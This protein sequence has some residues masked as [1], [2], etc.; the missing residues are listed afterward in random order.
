MARRIE[1]GHSRRRARAL[2]NG[3][4]VRP[5]AII[6][7][8]RSSLSRLTDGPFEDESHSNAT[9]RTSLVL[10]KHI[11]QRRRSNPSKR[12]EA[13]RNKL[14]ILSNE[15]DNRTVTTSVD[16]CLVQCR[17][18]TCSVRMQSLV[19]C[20]INLFAIRN[21]SMCTLLSCSIFIRSTRLVRDART[22]NERLTIGRRI[23]R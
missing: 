7:R 20:D 3:R 4:H 5:E 14:M 23:R 19:L 1:H 13:N 8:T 17:T 22:T 10:I 15:T 16:S 2:L 18:G 9:R 11:D 6:V 21:R 12:H